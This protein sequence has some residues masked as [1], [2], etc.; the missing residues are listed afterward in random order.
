MFIYFSCQA[1]FG[2]CCGL[3]QKD[4]SIACGSRPTLPDVQHLRDRGGPP[5]ASVT[6]TVFLRQQEGLSGK[7]SPGPVCPREGTNVSYL[8]DGETLG[9]KCSIRGQTR[10]TRLKL[11]HQKTNID[12]HLW[13]KET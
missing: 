5:T 1:L 10:E 13:P 6:L 4:G 11:G 8:K 12:K 2:G 9:G 7:A 3:Q